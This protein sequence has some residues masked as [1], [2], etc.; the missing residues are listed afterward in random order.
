MKYPNSCLTRR[1]LLLLS[2]LVSLLLCRRP[3]LCTP[4]FRT[5]GRSCQKSA[6]RTSGALA[7]FALRCRTKERKILDDRKRDL[8]FRFR[9]T[10][11]RE[12]SF[13]LL[14]VSWFSCRFTHI[15]YR[16]VLTK[17]IT[18]SWFV[19][20]YLI[21]AFPVLWSKVNV[22]LKILWQISRKY[23]NV[24]T[25]LIFAAR[26][27]IWIELQPFYDNAIEQY[28]FLLFY[29]FLVSFSLQNKNIILYNFLK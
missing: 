2:I 10:D 8:S 24:Q 23:C 26:N 25:F 1:L 12:W 9:A 7:A 17:L 27:L 11:T 22:S 4:H 13:V 14:C 6:F 15:E 28:S 29:L 3:S 21:F 16:D 5:S 18:I 20:R 19:F